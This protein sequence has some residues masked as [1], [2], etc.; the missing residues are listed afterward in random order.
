MTALTPAL[1]AAVSVGCALAA[2]LLLRV[3]WVWRSPG[4]AIVLWQALGLAGGLS[5]LGALAAVALT[6]YRAGVLPATALLAADLAQGR[7][8]P[9]GLVRLTLLSGTALATCWLLA[10]PVLTFVAAARLRHRHAGVLDLVARAEPGLAGALV[11]DHP[12]LTAYCLPG[13]L[14]TARSR[15][16]VS[17]GALDALDSVALS[18]VLAHERTH[19]QE[20]HDLV[21]LPFTAL[22]RAFSRWRL[23]GEAYAAVALL[24]EMRADD[25]AR[26]H[27]PPEVLVRALLRFGQAATPAGALGADLG[28]LVRVAR[29]SRPVERPDRKSVV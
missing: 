5:A 8:L 18:G 1:L 14:P 24:V 21:L 2:Y 10:A 4:P 19:A 11:I 13:A 3:A 22:T 15:L 12:A 7:P 26:D 17:T 29:L 9:L 27:C 6:P 20:R 16:V 28:L 25:R 23:A